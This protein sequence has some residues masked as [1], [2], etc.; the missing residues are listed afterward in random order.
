M[1]RSKE[2]QQAPHPGTYSFVRAVQ[3]ELATARAALRQEDGLR[4]LVKIHP[5]FRDELN[6]IV[7]GLGSDVFATDATFSVEQS[8]D[9]AEA[10]NTAAMVVSYTVFV[11][12]VSHYRLVVLRADRR[13]SVLAQD[14]PDGV[15]RALVQ[16][17]S[18]PLQVTNRVDVPVGNAGMV[19]VTTATADRSAMLRVEALGDVP[20][21]L[22]SPEMAERVADTIAG[23]E[24]VVMPTPA[25]SVTAPA[26]EP[27]TEQE[28]EERFRRV[29]AELLDSMNHGYQAASY[30]DPP[31]PP[32][33]QPPVGGQ[34]IPGGAPSF[35]SG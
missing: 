17:W 30:D 23:R 20:I 22:G 11:T 2:S 16:L 18:A 34:P 21:P 13:V 5:E 15:N 32:G 9:P 10:G 3:G 26:A 24:D 19:S 6:R 35:H 33:G 25:E 7:R 12:L 1:R 29:G 8:T 31:T 28:R 14:H 4:L 27:E